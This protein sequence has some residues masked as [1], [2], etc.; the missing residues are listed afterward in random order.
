MDSEDTTGKTIAATRL[1]FAVPPQEAMRWNI[2]S[3]QG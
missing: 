2:R 1:A 3:S